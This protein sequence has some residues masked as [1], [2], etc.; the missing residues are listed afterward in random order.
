MYLPL[1]VCT[2]LFGDEF[3]LGADDVSLR[4]VLQEHCQILG[5]PDVTN[6]LTKPESEDLK[7][8]P[9]LLL[10]RQFVRGRNDAVLKSDDAIH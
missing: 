4:T 6:Q 3:F 8:V 10:W 5:V 9:D 1:I 7:D 2:R